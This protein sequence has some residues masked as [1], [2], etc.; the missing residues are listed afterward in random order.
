MNFMVEYLTRISFNDV[1]IIHQ[2]VYL[3]SMIMKFKTLDKR[4]EVNLTD[5]RYSLVQIN[6]NMA[7]KDEKNC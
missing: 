5:F 6:A 2:Q 1:V 3:L 7:A 4:I